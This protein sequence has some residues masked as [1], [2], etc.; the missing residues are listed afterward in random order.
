M[1]KLEQVIPETRTIILIPLMAGT[2]NLKWEWPCLTHS[3]KKRL[4]ENFI[5]QVLYQVSV[6]RV[7]LFLKKHTHMMKLLP[8]LLSRWLFRIKEKMASYFRSK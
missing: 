7:K 3:M 2:A 4:E 8:I 5:L 6:D 1:G